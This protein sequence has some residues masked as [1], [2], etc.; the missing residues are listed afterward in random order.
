MCTLF[1]AVF[2]AHCILRSTWNSILE[3]DTK[4][5]CVAAGKPP[6]D[7]LMEC[8]LRVGDK[9]LVAFVVT[10]SLFDRH[11]F[12]LETNGWAGNRTGE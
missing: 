4:V 7:D 1:S 12:C 6:L 11:E 3:P 9:V 8:F 10:D 5:I 2:G